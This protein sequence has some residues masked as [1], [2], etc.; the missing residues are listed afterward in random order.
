[1]K[2]VNIRQI[3]H[4]LRSIL[5]R[6]EQGEEITILNR[7]RAVARICPPLPKTPTK[8]KLPDFAARARTILGDRLI[9]NTALTEREERPW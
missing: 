4:D 8:T 3:H 9:T 6:V 1:M 2:T 7:S 5:A